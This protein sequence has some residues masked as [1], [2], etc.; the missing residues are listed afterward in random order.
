M[1][2]P[3]QNSI[4]NSIQNAF[5][6]ASSQYQKIPHSRLRIPLPNITESRVDMSIN[7]CNLI[8]P[9]LKEYTH[10]NST[11]LTT[12]QFIANFLLSNYTEYFVDWIQQFPAVADIFC[13]F[14]EMIHYLQNPTVNRFKIAYLFYLSKSDM[15]KLKKTLLLPSNFSKM[16]FAEKAI[17]II[18]N[19]KNR[20]LLYPEELPIINSKYLHAF[21]GFY[22]NA[23]KKGISI[24]TKLNNNNS[25]PDSFY[26]RLS[27]FLNSAIPVNIS[28]IMFETIFMRKMETAQQ[29]LIWFRRVRTGTANPIN[30]INNNNVNNN[31]Q[32]SNHIGNVNEPQDYLQIAQQ[33][34]QLNLLDPRG[35]ILA[36]INFHVL[37][38]RIQQSGR[39]VARMLN[40]YNIDN[41]SA[42]Q[43]HYYGITRQKGQSSAIMEKTIN[44]YIHGIPESNL[45]GSNHRY[46][47][48]PGTIHNPRGIISDHEIRG[49]IN[50]VPQLPNFGPISPVLVPV[51]FGLIPDQFEMFQGEINPFD[52]LPQGSFNLNQMLP[53][54]GMNPFDALPQGNLNLNLLGMDERLLPEQINRILAII[55]NSQLPADNQVQINNLRSEALRIL[56]DVKV[57]D[58]WFPPRIYKNTSII[59]EN[60]IINFSNM[61]MITVIN[62]QSKI[63][64]SILKKQ[65]T[66]IENRP[67]YNLSSE[68]AIYI[69]NQVVDNI[70]KSNN[71]I[72][73]RL[74]D[75]FKT[76]GE[77]ITSSGLIDQNTSK[78]VNL[79]FTGY[80][81][82]H[83][84]F[85]MKTNKHSQID[86]EKL[87]IIESFVVND[88]KYNKNY[89]K[90]NRI[91]SSKITPLV[92]N[93]DSFNNK[94]HNSSI[95]YN[96][97]GTFYRLEDCIEYAYRKIIPVNITDA[98]LHD[99]P[100]IREHCIMI[101]NFP[102]V[103]SKEMY[104]YLMNLEL[105][106]LDI[107]NG[108]VSDQK[109][110]LFS[111]LLTIT[112]L[113]IG[114]QPEILLNTITYKTKQMTSLSDRMLK[115]L[116]N[117]DKYS[118]RYKIGRTE[119]DSIIFFDNYV[120]GELIPL[121]ETV[122]NIRDPEKIKNELQMVIP[123]GRNPLDYMTENLEHYNNYYNNKNDIKRKVLNGNDFL[124]KI[125][126]TS[127]GM[128][129]KIIPLMSD[130]EL[131]N[132]ID[133][134]VFFEGRLNLEDIIYDLFHNFQKIFFIPFHRNAIN[135]ET[136][137]LF[138]CNDLSVPMIAY[139]T[140][141]NY[142]C[143][144]IDELTSSF[145]DYTDT[146]NG[147]NNDEILG[148]VVNPVTN[149]KMYISKVIFRL[150]EDK[151]IILDVTVVRELISL[152]P[153]MLNI[154]RKSDCILNEK[155]IDKYTIILNKYLELY[156]IQ[157][158]DMRSLPK[159]FKSLPGVEKKKLEE[160]FELLFVT[161]MYMR[162]WNG[163][164][165]YPL[166]KNQTLGKEP[167][168]TIHNY[169][170]KI[171]WCMDHMSDE[172][173]S[174][175]F[176]KRWG[177]IHEKNIIND[178]EVFVINSKNF[179][180][181]KLQI[182]YGSTYSVN[183]YINQLLIDVMRNL[184][185]IR[186]SSKTLVDTAVYY[187]KLF[188]EKNLLSENQDVEAIS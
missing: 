171:Q 118:Y 86:M 124:N 122:N 77:I 71:R 68:D 29:I 110:F 142:R 54:Q 64:S 145:V 185:C 40:I 80:D 52:I 3:P 141:Y 16:D 32:I 70:P 61:T 42:F 96:T 93:E 30:N 4:Q 46:N 95:T 177:N 128:I 63:L 180:G 37:L 131:L 188:F 20:K 182:K 39:T 55:Q 48:E 126:T 53:A 27:L 34:L 113:S 92:S 14:V 22:L 166:N 172:T 44:L 144:D 184:V 168:K 170:G 65:K 81:F 165:P 102:P 56:P 120:N 174:T 90:Y 91:F 119:M 147:V 26:T 169:Y 108:Y 45:N 73:E 50:N 163:K 156:N 133:G 152:L 33:L 139:G 151:K 143:Y 181:L 159:K 127:F 31:L 130:M 178:R 160:F 134:Y 13:T 104:C 149:E 59:N 115:M 25:I 69:F 173:I 5:P 154:N 148:E 87:G 136:F 89:Y 78:I 74:F 38:R 88:C 114:S 43:L 98:I 187:S 153:G 2:L 1:S 82:R 164:G 75:F 84:N 18:N 8:Y 132:C 97:H 67:F 72:S 162:R 24:V 35:R 135:K 121:A 157:E 129:N 58:C 140:P 57:Q 167:I 49:Q 10:T 183:G 99:Y 106:H 85:S 176:D 103:I 158:N 105:Y 17:T 79:T 161:G 41:I 51:P 23:S 66:D 155:D 94:F 146:K 107:I 76:Y 101:A 125:Y 179:S 175:L 112:F 6:V 109:G 111:P 12:R 28:P 186:V 137:T 15:N 60:Y 19:L 47:F 62:K 150:P 123:Y 11:G 36:D 138:E 116:F 7:D 83:F 100:Y 117:I 9:L 21:F